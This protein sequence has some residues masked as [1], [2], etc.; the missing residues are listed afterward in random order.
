MLENLKYGLILLMVVAISCAVL[1]YV[2]S[3]TEPLISENKRIAEE[4][5]RKNIFPDLES[6]VSIATSQLDYLEI[7]DINNVL[8]G[9]LFISTGKGYNGDIV[10]M[11]GVTTE[12]AIKKVLVLSQ[13]ETPGLGD[14]IKSTSFLDNFIN[15]KNQDLRISNDGGKIMNITGATVSSRAIT[16]SIREHIELLMEQ[17]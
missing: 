8:L 5:A 3:V 13:V 14:K 16:N 12:F 10:A 1:A 6:T 2:N 9:Y 11:V 17:Y 15:L 7:Y 4:N